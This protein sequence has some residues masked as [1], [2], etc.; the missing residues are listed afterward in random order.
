MA[1][2]AF[3]LTSV[4]FLSAITA[5]RFAIQ[6]REVAV[7]DVTGKPSAEAQALLQG[8][9]VGMKVEERLYNAAAA[10]TVIRQSPAAGSRVKIGQYA[11]VVVSLGP[12]KATIPELT[13]H[14]IRA[15][16]IELL[17]SGLQ[18]GEIS[19][20]YLSGAEDDSVLQQDP[21]PGTSDVTSPHVDMLVS[22][23][24]RPAAFVM[25]ELMGMNLLEAQQRLAGT[26]LRIG[27]INVTPEPG[28]IHGTVLGQTPLR[29]ARVD[30]GSAIDLQVAE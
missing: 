23:G 13:D 7:P 9:G 15:A 21:A 8:R 3:I 27:K 11:H 25:P 18:A 28:A 24:P 10:D 22:L 16:R 4:A 12:Q 20:V 17:R 19:S 6:G 5:M 1:L 30:A 26:G 29:G 2:L 14:S